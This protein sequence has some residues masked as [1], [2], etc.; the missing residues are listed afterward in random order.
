MVRT[1]S[2]VRTFYL[3]AGTQLGLGDDVFFLE[4]PELI[5]Q[6]EGDGIPHTVIARR[7]T[8]YE[9]LVTL[10][11]Y[12]GIIVGRFEP[13]AWASDPDQPFD[14]FDARQPQRVP[15][16]PSDNILR[17]F[18]G[19]AGLVQGVVRRLDRP[20]DGHLLQPGEILVTNTTNVGWDTHLSQSDGH[21]HRRR[22]AAFPRRHRSPGT[23]NSCGRRHRQRNPAPA[24]W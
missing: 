12:P 21:R 10:P 16:G 14:R 7:R 6:L 2:T 19:A 18:A 23:G 9:I 5:A 13:E 15:P 8:R 4:Y 24:G 3:R 20:E 17:G 1:F 11:R 22:R